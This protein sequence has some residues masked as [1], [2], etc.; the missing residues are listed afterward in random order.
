MMLIT[1]V[2]EYVALA[3]RQF[4]P[5]DDVVDDVGASALQVV[6]SDNLFDNQSSTYEAA[7][8]HVTQSTRI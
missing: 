7:W 6:D 1:R 3:E 2:E 8:L 4:L 5:V